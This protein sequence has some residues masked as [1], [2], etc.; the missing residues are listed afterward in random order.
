MDFKLPENF[1]ELTN[2]EQQELNG[3]CHYWKHHVY[4]VPVVHYVPVHHCKPPVPVVTTVTTTTVTE[5]VTQTHH[6]SYH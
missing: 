1:A 5:E 2:E 3:G 4:Y 6:V